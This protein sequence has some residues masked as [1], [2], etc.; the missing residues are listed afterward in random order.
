MMRS[1]CKRSR[2]FT[3]IE[4]VVSLAIGAVLLIG[5]T[6]T[7]MQVIKNS[8][9]TSARTVVVRNVDTTGAWFVRD[10]Q[11][12]SMSQLPPSVVLIPTSN[13]T[14]S[15]TI[16]QSLLSASDT[17]IRYTIDATN[18]LFRNN[19]TSGTTLMIA[20]NISQVQYITGSNTITV[21][22]T[23]GTVTTTRSYQ[24]SSRVTG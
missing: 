18:H 23:S 6:T 10:F 1:F 9:L 2:G 19:V 15:L 24:I 22:S 12:T 7:A 5:L 20:S 21:I 13:G 14:P 17:Q 11:S 8:Q 16:N 4:L 3:L